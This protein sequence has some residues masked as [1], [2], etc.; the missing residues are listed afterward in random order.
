MEFLWFLLIGATAGWWAGIM[1]Q[2]RS[3]GLFNNMLIGISG[4]IF[5]GELSKLIK[6]IEEDITVQLLA[7]TIGAIMALLIVFMVKRKEKRGGEY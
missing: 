4:S 6:L 5:T 2:K 1:F 3:Y 7:A